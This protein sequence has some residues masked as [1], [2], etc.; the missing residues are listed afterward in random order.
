MPVLIA[1]GPGWAQELPAEV[2]HVGD[3]A[4]GVEA[5]RTAMGL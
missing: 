2:V 4:G 5:I 1:G 3:M